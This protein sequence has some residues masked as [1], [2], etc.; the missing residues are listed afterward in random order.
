MGADYFNSGSRVDF[1]LP[2]PT[3]GGTDN[4]GNTRAI[5]GLLRLGAPV[6][7]AQADLDIVVRHLQNADPDRW[8]LGVVLS[9]LQIHVGGRFK[10]AMLFPSAAAVGVGIA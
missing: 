5:I 6:T 4:Q 2:F 3:S 9:G 7:S 1:L 8:G 10:T